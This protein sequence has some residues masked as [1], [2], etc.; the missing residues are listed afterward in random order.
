MERAREYGPVPGNTLRDLRE[1]KLVE[2]IRFGSG[3]GPF[4]ITNEGKRALRSL[5]EQV[6][7]LAMF[8]RE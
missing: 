2:H 7:G 6:V 5:L 8:L 1:A 3:Q 4:Q